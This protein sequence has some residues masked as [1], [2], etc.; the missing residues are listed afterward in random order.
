MICEKRAAQSEEREVLS[1]HSSSLSPRLIGIDASRSLRTEPTGT[2][3]YSQQ[4]IGHMLAAHSD[5]LAFRLYAPA[6]PTAE[7]MHGD[8]PPPHDQR[9][10]TVRALPGN[11]LWTHRRHWP[12]RSAA[13]RPT[14]SLCLPTLC[15][16]CRPRCCRPPS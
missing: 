16:S 3:R 5:R 4:I 2:E 6:M 15:P 14:C 1:P 7:A 12:G 9:A 13:A 8:A 11:R 10:V